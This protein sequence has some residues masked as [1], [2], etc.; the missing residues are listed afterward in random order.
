MSELINNRTLRVQRIK[1]L[2][3]ELHNG[4][5]SEAVRKE[6]GEIMGK[7]PYGDVVQAEQELIE[8]GLS[9]EEVIKY[10]DLHSQAMRGNMETAV[11]DN[12][13]PGHPVDT[14]VKE[15]IEIRA[16]L[17]ILRDA[18]REIDNYKGTD[19][20]PLILKIKGGINMLM[21]LDKHYLRKENLIFPFLEKN[22]ITAPPMV[23]WGKHDAIRELLNSAQETLQ[24]TENI[25]HESLSGVTDLL[26]KPLV[27]AV[28]E[29]IF[30][31]EQIL[32]PMCLDTL[33]ELDWYQ[34]YQ[35][36]EDIGYCLIAPD[37]K[38][39]PHGMSAQPQKESKKDGSVKLSTGSF[40]PEELDALFKSLPFDITFVDKDDR[41]K[42]FSHGE[43]R[44]FARNKSILGRQVQYCH[45]P[46]SVNI[47]D[48][49]LNDFK[50]KK[51]DKATFWINL[52][53]MFVHIAYYAVRDE[54]GEYLG[55]VE[56]SQDLTSYR[57][58]EGEKR[59]LDYSSN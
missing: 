20:L 6:L 54:N 36:T 13:P 32:I 16:V 8:E 23:M 49:I 33:T 45:P 18:I 59:I 19:T 10:C 4:A 43:K 29:M 26:Y 42:Y 21:D 38:W 51:Q 41:V 57:T 9:R 28:D 55:T 1:T 2:I 44:I 12:I 50:D 22:G 17:L 15:N 34:I 25:D 35:D 31:E 37:S 46:S 56:V 40:K 39:V 24:I 53:G 11:Y 47:V 5:E 7:V 27:N 3:L 48:Q 58:I 52:K 30:K 14:L